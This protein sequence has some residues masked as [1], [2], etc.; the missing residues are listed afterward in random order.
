MDLDQLRA[1]LSSPKAD[2]SW[3][4]L[5]ARFGNDPAAILGDLIPR[6]VIDPTD[7]DAVKPDPIVTARLRT[8]A[9]VLARLSADPDA[10]V[11]AAERDDLAL[12]SLLAGRPA[13]PVRAGKYVNP[14]PQWAFLDRTR[15]DSR[16]AAVGRID[17][18]GAQI[19]T[20]FVVSANTIMTNRHVAKDVEQIA[21][22]TLTGAVIDFDRELEGGSRT[23]RLVEPIWVSTIKE[24][25]LAL[26]RIEGDA[27][28][29]PLYMQTTPPPSVEDRIVFAI[30]YPFCDNAGTTPTEVMAAV[31]REALGI[32]RVQPGKL[33]GIDPLDERHVRHDCST[34]GGS[35]G[36]CI[37]DYATG[38]V[39]GLHYRGT[40]T[41]SNLAVALW[42]VADHEM[43]GPH[44]TAG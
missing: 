37:I 41:K 6:A 38:L 30:G 25:D 19:G 14:P 8:A 26:F 27:I 11:T 15:I 22:S 3:G 17:V 2:D 28:P 40:Y 32:K 1:S 31:F 34:L 23:A 21:G 24:I 16:L 39:C 4:E 36:S 35:S 13:I 42:T 43:I 44:I 20:G 5:V 7:P 18:N 12:L 33:R 10:N 29:K 9:S